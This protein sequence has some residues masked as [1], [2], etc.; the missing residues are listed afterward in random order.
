MD[1][2]PTKHRTR[3]IIGLTLGVVLVAGAIALAQPNVRR[4]LDFRLTDKIGAPPPGEP[5]VPF[6][7]ADLPDVRFA[8]AGDVGTGGE[9][10]QRTADAMD[11][12][13][14]DMEYAAL[15]LLGDNVY[16]NGDPAKLSQTVFEPFAGVLDGGT[17]LLAVLGN[18]DVRDGHGDAQAEALGM[19]SRWYSTHVGDVLVIAL[20]SNQPS[21]PEQLAWLESELQHDTS[22]WTIAILHHPAY[23]AGEHGSDMSVRE[24]FSPLFEQYGVD[25]VLSGHDHDYQ[26]STPIEGI[27][28]VVSGAAAELRDTDSASFTAV[29]W[30]TY[31][32]VD[33]AVYDDHIELQAID[34][35]GLVF[36]RVSL[37]QVAATG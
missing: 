25:L 3:W 19:P 15:L 27:T 16:P 37:P 32:F 11:A 26:R 34:Q 24:H 2:Q 17:E 18:H 21:N 22:P 20:D 30:S 12:T 6:T 4:W 33:L 28:Y 10:E 29:A 35:D 5:Y 14:G 13:E 36:D 23:S 8:V 9:A 31:S 7:S 1:E